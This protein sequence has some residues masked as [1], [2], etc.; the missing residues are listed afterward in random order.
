MSCSVEP[1]NS[2]P[3]G[4]EHG[5]FTSLFRQHLALFRRAQPVRAH[6]VRA[7]VAPDHAAH[8]GAIVEGVQLEGVGDF[9]ADADAAHAVALAVDRRGIDGDADLARDHGDDAA[10]QAALGRHADLVGPYRPFNPIVNAGAIAVAELM[11]GDTQ[12]QRIANM[13]GLFSRLAGRKLEIDEAV[14]RCAAP[15]GS[16]GRERARA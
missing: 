6:E 15:P 7:V 4:F 12:G 11:D 2:G 3:W 1:K 14:Y 5:N 9:L 8:I 13:L 10:R 16:L